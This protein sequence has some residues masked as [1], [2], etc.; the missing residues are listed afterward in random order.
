[1]ANHNPTETSHSQ[2][3][4]TH[5]DLSQ[6]TGDLERF[7][8]PYNRKVLYTPGVKFLAEKAEAYGLMDD[9]A[10]NYGSEQMIEAMNRDA[11]LKS[12]Q[13][14]RLELTDNSAVLIAYADVG[15][16]PFIR[17]EISYTDFPLDYVEIWAGY[18]GQV[19]TL[20]ARNRFQ[21]SRS[22]CEGSLLST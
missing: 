3:E 5:A 13:L 18:D 6:F 8:R 1:M 14:W 10:S 7:Y 21:L 2:A 19:W 9:I 17:Q 16:E 15:E 12:L 20:Y 22:V 11:R 4:L